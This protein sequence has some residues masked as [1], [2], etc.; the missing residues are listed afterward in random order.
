MHDFD[1]YPQLHDLI[2][3][4]LNQGERALDVRL[5]RAE[6]LVEWL[7]GSVRRTLSLVQEGLIET[8]K[9]ILK[10]EQK[11]T[12]E[13]AAAM[14]ESGAEMLSGI[15][16][17]F[18]QK[19]ADRGWGPVGWLVALWARF[20]M[21]GAS[22]LATLRFRNPLLQF[23]GLISSLSRYRKTRMAVEEATT[24]GDMASVLL[25]Y[26]LTIQQAWPDLA[27]R[28]IS[29][30]FNNE[31]REASAVLQDEKDLHLRLAST[32][33]NA[34]E[35][36]MNRRV[37]KIS[38]F[39]VQLIFNLPTLAVMGLFAYQSVKGFL[40]QQ[41]LASGYFLHATVSILMVVLLSFFL[42]Q[43]LVHFVGGWNL[44]NPVTKRLVALGDQVGSGQHNPSIIKEIDAVLRLADER[45]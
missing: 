35:E 45:I 37:A 15:Q 30:G 42:L 44:L 41:T 40:F 28:L 12:L 31:V 9:D 10:L 4:T 11:A 14:K 39:I 17:L 19:L 32:W 23:W 3:K 29:L 8:R 27:G 25:K 36:E 18:Y 5:E 16:A 26:R 21:A 22:V 38:A 43:I 24:G 1:Q 2:F 20:L 7:Q 13:A 6:H 34:L 33:K